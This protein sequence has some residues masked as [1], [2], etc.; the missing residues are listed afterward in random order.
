MTR[1]ILA[2]TTLVTLSFLLGSVPA[3]AVTSCTTTISDKRIDGDVIVPA[4]KKCDLEGVDVIGNVH[5]G[6]GSS[7]LADVSSAAPTTIVGNVSAIQCYSV[8]FGTAGPVFVNGNVQITGCTFVALTGATISAYLECS[9]NPGIL[10]VADNTVG[11][12]AQFNNNGGLTA[13]G[14]YIGG[15]LQCL[16]NS[17]VTGSGGNKVAGNIRGQCTATSQ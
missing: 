12:N 5:V 7:F 2:V 15:N 17:L 13:P 14:N 16:G 4:G 8:F 10:N 3:A 6:K 11:G 9:S 1:H